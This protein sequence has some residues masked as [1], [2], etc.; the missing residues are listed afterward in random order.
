M[1]PLLH[2]GHSIGWLRRP[3]AMSRLDNYEM[4]ES[5]LTEATRLEE[6]E[7][8]FEGA[9]ALLKDLICQDPN[10][11]EAYIHLAADSGL[12]RRF[13]QA[14]QYAR[15]GLNL[16]PTSGRARY[17]LACALRSQGR[18]EEAYVEMEQALIQ[19]RKAAVKGT[20]AEAHWERFPLFGWNKHVEDDAMDLRAWMFRHK[21]EMSFKNIGLQ[22]RMVL[23]SFGI[24]Y[25]K[26]DVTQFVSIPGEMKTYRN[27]R[28]GFEI[29]VPTEWLPPAQVA[30]EGLKF[31]C[32]SNEAFNI[33][34]GP[35]ISETSLDDTEAEFKR[36]AQKKGY[37]AVE[38]GRITVQGRDHIWARYHMAG[39]DW[40]KKY[41]IVFGQTEFSITATYFNQKEFLEKERILDEIV[42]S[43]RLLVP[44]GSMQ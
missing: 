32:S 27:V 24:E 36:Y 5:I 1:T 25:D 23:R 31:N 28:H 14:E 18:L 30:V 2:P 4:H 21:F 11:I 37:T 34:M 33:Q 20:G 17:Y 16:D 39:G 41:L 12:L 8:D 43:F 9:I 22:L 44:N 26:K 15:N 40:T 29:D 42:A 10:C 35:M 3:T 7:R 38:F 19:V 6:T 13:S